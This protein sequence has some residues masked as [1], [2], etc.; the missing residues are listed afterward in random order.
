V[1]FDRLTFVKFPFQDIDAQR[2]KQ[3]ALDDSFQRASAVNRIVTFAGEKRFGSVRQFESD[4]LLSEA[5][6]KTANLYLNDLFQITFRK[7]IEDDD[8]VNPIQ[9]F[10]AKM[11]P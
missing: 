2:I 8:L 5:F 11:C 7:P 1:H 6:G 4:V 9:K 3:I 10:R